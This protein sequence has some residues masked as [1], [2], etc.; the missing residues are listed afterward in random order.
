MTNCQ[1]KIAL[2]VG[3]ILLSLPVQP[4]PAA[5]AQV[6]RDSVP[7]AVS[8][9]APVG[10]LPASNHLDLVISLP[11]RNRERLAVLLREIYDP[12]SPNYRRYLTP[13]QFAEQ[14]APTEADYQSVIAHANSQ[15]LKVTG[16]YPNRTL[17]DVN[18]AVA[19]IEKTF[20]VSLR[21]YPHPSEARAF[22]APDAAP[23]LDLAVPVLAVS[24]LDDYILPRPM[25]LRTNFF[26]RNANA[27]PMAAG[28]GPIGNFL[29]KDFR[30]AYAPGVALDGAGQCLGLFELD[31]YNA[32]DISD[33]EA[34][35]GLPNVLLTNVLLDGVSGKPSANGIEAPLD[36]EMAV[37]MAPGLSR[38][39]VYEGTNSLHILAQMA[40]DNLAGQ[41]S[42]SWS[43]GSQVDPAREQFFQQFELQGQSFFQ[44]SGDLGAVAGPLPPPSDDP[45]VTVVGG[46]SLSTS[47]HGGAWMS[48]T[49]W[50]DSTGG[51]ST[52]YP[53]PP[54]QQGV[55]MSTNQGS[56]V[57][58]NVPDVACLA[59]SVLW[60]VVKNGQQGVAGGTSAAAP[61]WAAFAALANQQAAD[62][63]GPRLGFLNPA[64]YAIGGGSGYPAAFHDITTGNNTNS[65]SVNKF[66]AVPGYDLC[67]GWGTPAGG[68]LIAALLAPPD[69]LRIGPGT[70]LAFDGPSGGPFSPAAATWSLTNT[71]AAPL[72][73][74]VSNSP[75]WLNVTPAGGTLAAGGPS[76]MVTAALTAAAGNL[77]VGSYPAL[78]M[79]TN[80][81]D[82]F[83]Q[84]RQVTL[85]VDAPPQITSQPASLAVRAG[86][87]AT[88][89]VGAAANGWLSYQW[90]QDNGIYLTNLTD[91]GNL[92]GSASSLLTI[93]NVSSANVGIYSVIVSNSAGVT[94]SSNA[95]LTILP[96][97]P[98][99]VA[100][101]AGASALA[102]QTIVLAVGAVGNQPLSYQWQE[103]GTNLSDGG[104]LSGSST[105][106]LTFQNITAANAGT[107]S[108]VVSNSF[109]TAASS[110]AV[111]SV[112]SAGA[113]GAALA[114]L[115]SFTGG[116]DG[117][118]P[119]GLMEGAN[120][121]LYGTTR[122][123]GSNSW[124]TVFQ[125]SP[126]GVPAGLY[127]F[128]GGNDGATPF[129][130]PEQ[131]ADGSFYG[132]TLLGGAYG[133]GTVFR[134]TPGGAVAGLV[135]FNIT[136]G[137]LPYG[138]LTPYA[139]GSLYGT[140]DQG[141]A[142]S[143]GA[144]Y[145]VSTNGAT[146]LLHSFT[147]GGDGG[148]PVAGLLLGADG[149]F[150]G[151]TY[152]GGA[153]GYGTV[154]RISTNGAL[155]TLVSLAFTNGAYPCSGLAQDAVGNFYGATSQGGAGSNGTVFMMTPAG[156]LTSLYSFTGGADGA[157]PLGG[158]VCAADGNFYGTTASGG[159]YGDG[160]LFTLAP[161]GAPVTLAQF[162]GFNGAN[163]QAPL[164]ERADGILQGTTPNGGANNQGV[165]F[166]LAI[167]SAPQITAQPASQ[168]VFLGQSLQ[169]GVAVF[170]SAPLFYQ[171]QKNGTN[172]SDG[173]SIS[174][175]AA[176]VLNLASATFADAGTYSVIVSNALGFSNSAG[177]LLT[178]TSSAPYIVTQ[179]A[180]QTLAPGT[181]TALVA[182]ALGNMPLLYQWQKDG[183][184]LSDGGN[185]SG[186]A[187]SVLTFAS[188]TEANNGTYRLIVSNSL[189]SAA[190]SNA[191]LAVIPPSAAGTSLA[192][193]YSF[194]D[195]SAGGTPNAL[196]AG[197]NGLL[198]GTTQSGGLGGA[199]FTVNT[200]G[201][202]ATL[203]RFGPGTGFTPLAG[204]AQGG[205]GNFYGSTEF[206]GT[207]YL[208]NIF[209]M[210][211]EGVLINLYSFTGGS[212]GS[213]PGAALVL[214][215]DG[216]FYGTTATGGVD[217]AGN[218]FKITPGGLLTNL[219][220][221]TNGADGSSP[222][223]PLALGSDGNFYGMT[224]G[225]LHGCGN[226]FKMTPGGAL[227]NLYSFTGGA[228]GSAP[229][230]ALT[231]GADG[232]FYGVTQHNVIAGFPF[233]GTIFKITPNGALTTI[234]RLNYTDGAYPSAGLI[235]G[236]DG[237]FY[238]TTWTGYAD[239]NGTVFSVTPGGVLTTLVVFDGF[240][241]GAHPETALVEG[242]DGNLYGTTSAGGPGGFGSVF[243]LGFTSA[244]QFTS[245]PGSQTVF[246]G[247]GAT[248][249][250]TVFGA[251]PLFYQWHINTTNLAG[252]NNVSGAASRVLSLTNITMANA[253]TYTLIVSNALGSITSSGAV[254]TVIPAP[255]FQSI[256]LDHIGGVTFI[257][258]TV[259]GH[260]YQLQSAPDLTSGNWANIGSAFQPARTFWISG[261]AISNSQQFYRVEL[262]R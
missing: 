133:N 81:N 121:I 190:S 234:Y 84:S 196:A 30:A 126:A 8:R 23:S 155:T 42:S 214:G 94:V 195:D 173:G 63:G 11:L 225:G 127:S 199:V 235:Q 3:A 222:V 14:F 135:S 159:V 89:A 51:I 68:N 232:N 146:T 26:N 257:I 165:I 73:W 185:V 211:P 169:F 231:Q 188:V 60:V 251:P 20:H 101:P 152:A 174:G 44:A 202:V 148:Q 75:A 229:A 67:T 18:G 102:G 187:T 170:G 153:Y 157:Q 171:W 74:T 88:F 203:A 50:P 109:G 172:L 119:N 71:G 205:D 253:G 175:S 16:Q 33:Y 7:A 53:I 128:T 28:S 82:A 116:G 226:V 219:Y 105:G 217:G 117:G 112:A 162:D 218:I 227:S 258:S 249:S 54:W 122:Y 41:I 24:G 47:G 161:G 9:L 5:E 131:G 209:E 223:G 40:N 6:L 246:E 176:R 147:E 260:T 262:V 168:A 103:S 93:S 237:N 72:N 207:N 194:A 259:G 38:V 62:G 70:A 118:N 17:V 59:D 136:N 78:L 15:G 87:T 192:T 90:Q 123:G 160:T 124:G 221:F 182:A 80:Q 43:F 4:A 213:Y 189:S 85:T 233:Y 141:G 164:A 254:L 250:A 179:P 210:T 130:A 167:T 104:N 108:V 239:T 45:W 98:V 111:L 76:A 32:S 34:L 140:C 145:R 212:D 238:G 193:L 113:P 149:N 52:S 154:Y 184:N 114:A 142:A 191:V 252:G 12:G 138:G 69:A 129:S 261:A 216:N 245:Q 100:E 206:G 166:S 242:A 25:G 29:G 31:G 37:A 224:A 200:N 110:A 247:A 163:P 178:V 150:Y 143:Y 243:R 77:P 106:S 204:L 197:T 220:S 86:A 83:G 256:M 49:V 236:G 21:L 95:T 144:A 79:F 27:T 177:A 255:V 201:T 1:S 36:I 61:L 99:I 158:L 180:G 120:G 244:P 10:R 208:G 186:A 215:A 13:R 58:R 241:D 134:M 55:N 156:S 137:N 57:M 228:D 132:T 35:A 22:Y 48:E 248:F 125:L 198:Y 56:P 46:T 91:G 230:G 151:A 107:Y 240:D 92:S 19:D 139:D 97:R 115:Y 183:T 66:F 39:I 181:N 64:L 65:S 96:F 2:A